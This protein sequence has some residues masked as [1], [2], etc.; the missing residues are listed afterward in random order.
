[1]VQQV[2]SLIMNKPYITKIPIYTGYL[3]IL[4]TQDFVKASRELG[5]EIQ[6]NANE[7]DGIAFKKCTGK[8]SGYILFVKTNR[9]DFWSI[10]THEALHITNYILEDAGIKISTDN[11][12]VQTYLL[13]YIMKHVQKYHTQ[14]HIKP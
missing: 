8:K 14:Y 2:N 4:F 1:M 13:G 7:F 10:L 5:V 9:K 6:P 11:D 3:Y 12:E